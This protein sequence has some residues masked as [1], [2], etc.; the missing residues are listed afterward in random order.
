MEEAY[1]N[2]TI[3][4]PKN[5]ITREQKN[6]LMPL[7]A[8]SKPKPKAQRITLKLKQKGEL[9]LITISIDS[10]VMYIDKSTII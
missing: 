6:Q 8:K 5:I 2:M 1:T 10:I 3:M 4:P 9:T 7:T